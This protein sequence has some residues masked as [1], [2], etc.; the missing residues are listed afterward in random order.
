MSTL[1]VDLCAQA[2]TG[3]AVTAPMTILL[4]STRQVHVENDKGKGRARRRV[5]LE[6]LRSAC[7]ACYELEWKC[8]QGKHD[9][10]N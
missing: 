2:V 9:G 10:A 8:G 4:T 6:K 3:L 5:A 7:V 1:V